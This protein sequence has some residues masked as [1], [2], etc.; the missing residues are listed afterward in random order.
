MKIEKEKTKHSK[1]LVQDDMDFWDWYTRRLTSD[2]A[3]RRDL[4]AQKSFSKLRSAIAGLYSNTGNR[5]QGEEAYR[6]ARVLYPLSPEAG[7]R[8]LQEV[9]LPQGRY[10]EAEDVLNYFVT[11]DPNNQKA[12]QFRE[13]VVKVNV[14][15]KK[16]KTIVDRGKKEKKLSSPDAYELAMSY[17]EIG[18]NQSAVHY[19]KRLAA[20]GAA[21]LPGNQR[22]EV[23]LALSTF[24]Q[25][26]DAV[27]V[28]DMVAS[29]LPPDVDFKVLIRIAAVYKDAKKVN[30]YVS[31]MM[32]I[33]KVNPRHWQSWLEM[34]D[35]YRAK[36]QT[37]Q[38]QYALQ[39]AFTIGQTPCLQALEKKP[40]LKN[41]A[42]PIIKQMLQQNPAAMPGVRR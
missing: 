36:G 8:M 15:Q 25:H 12:K 23:A 6:E 37:Q 10:E 4:P 39:K 30:Q 34:A 33:L 9:L 41:A 7:F 19:L 35:V 21:G 29:S 14:T 2:P 1:E 28:M 24:K 18:Q 20:T 31:I 27:K 11:K 13:F 40:E 16:I 5:V 22:L 17:R 26:E 38:M 42:I 3:F 32:R